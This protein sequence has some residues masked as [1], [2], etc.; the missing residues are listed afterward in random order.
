MQLEVLL[1]EGHHVG[2]VLPQG[3]SDTHEPSNE[4]LEL[5]RVSLEFQYKILIGPYSNLCKAHLVLASVG[6]KLSIIHRVEESNANI[7][8]LDVRSIIIDFGLGVV[9]D[10]SDVE[11]L[12]ALLEEELQRTIFVDFNRLHSQL[13]VYLQDQRIL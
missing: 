4:L 10:D 5:L 2:I 7:A 3:N 8:L 12:L 1:V 13:E 11:H 9:L 6:I